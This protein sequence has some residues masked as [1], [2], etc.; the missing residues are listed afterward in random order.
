MYF[1][2]VTNA[3]FALEEALAL[4][5][6]NHRARFLLV[7]CAMNADDYPRAKTEARSREWIS[8]GS[9]LMSARRVASDS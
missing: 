2:Q 9:F 5:P 6:T 3:W 8:R 4:C 7:S 1:A